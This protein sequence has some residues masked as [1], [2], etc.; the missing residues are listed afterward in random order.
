[1]FVHMSIHYPKPHT[2]DL[3]LDSMRRYGAAM[4]GKPGF[5]TASALRDERTGK[6]IGMAFW[7]SKEH[8]IAAK[9]AMDEAVK[10]DPFHEWEDVPPKVYH[11][12]EVQL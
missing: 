1:M 7:D 5:R 3:V 8:W 6:L 10:D 12:H 2:R 11:L 9:P 4:K